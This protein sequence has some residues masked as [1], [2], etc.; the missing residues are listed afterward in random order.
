MEKKIITFILAFILLCFIPITNATKLIAQGFEKKMFI[1]PEL[2]LGSIVPN[3]MKYPRSYPRVG[4]GATL[5]HI[6]NE[7]NGVNRYYRQPLVGLHASFHYLGEAQIFGNEINLLPVMAIPLKKGMIQIGIGVSYFTKTYQDNQLNRA[8]GS[9]LTWSFQSFYFRKFSLESGKTLR[10]GF[11]YLHGSN[12][13]TQ[14]PNYGI[15]SAVLSV[16]IYKNPFLKPMPLDTTHQLK[17]DKTFFIDINSGIGFH[18]FGGTTGPVNGSKALVYSTSAKAGIVFNKQFQ[19]YSG[20]GFR[21]YRHFADSISKS[22]TLQ[23]MKVTPNNVYFLLGVEYLVHHIGL[24]IE[25]GINL[26]KPFYIHFAKRFE[27]QETIKFDLRRI[28]L[29]RM[30]LKFYL[31]NTSNKPQHNVYLAPYINAN[32]SKADF[33]EIT[34]GY[35]YNFKR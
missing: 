13:H 31:F 3:Y 9:K 10:L 29:T 22:A 32:F 4:L 34:I 30:G 5:Y 2:Y 20:F 17:S 35:V 33:S 24:S 19:V 7:N 15:N 25:G 1:V 27:S 8:V 14:L 18:E 28:F 23:E 21:H 11:G 26:Y 16:G 6:S 12:G